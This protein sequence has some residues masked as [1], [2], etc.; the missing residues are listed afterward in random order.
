MQSPLRTWTDVPWLL[1]PET[2]LLHELRNSGF[3]GN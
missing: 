3:L 1:L 2:A